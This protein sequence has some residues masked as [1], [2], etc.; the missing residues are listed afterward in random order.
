MQVP[1]QI[2]NHI[3]VPNFV[4][5]GYFGLHP[6]GSTYSSGLLM[7]EG[8]I[9][10]NVAT[11]GQRVTTVCVFYD[12]VVQVKP[13][14]DLTQELGLRFAISGAGIY[15]DNRLVQ[16]GFTGVFSDI[17][18]DTDRT[19]VGYRESDNKIVICVVKGANISESQQIFKNLGVTAGIT[20]DGGGSTCCKVNGEYK[21]GTTRRINSIVTWN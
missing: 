1:D 20:L 5:G 19:I 7:S 14:E 11:H 2:A 15:P 3:E 17:G 8:K 4:N 6:D 10:S 9:I 21:I 18:R 13:I 16:E 12:G